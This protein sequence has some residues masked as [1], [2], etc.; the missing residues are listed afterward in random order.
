MFT[1]QIG[2]AQQECFGREGFTLYL[3][4]SSFNVFSPKTLMD[5]FSKD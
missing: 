2:K 4:D 5:F 1:F 3:A